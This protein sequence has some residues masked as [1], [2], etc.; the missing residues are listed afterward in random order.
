[1]TASANGGGNGEPVDRS[2]SG[3]GGDAADRAEIAAL[4]ARVAELEAAKA[5]AA[6]APAPVKKHRIR[7]FFS[8]LLIFLAW[9]LAPLAVVAAWS[10]SVVGDT[11]RYVS[12]VAPLAR[13]P[14][15]QQS[16]ANR[17]TDAIMSHLDIQ[18]LVQ[19]A[20]PADRPRLDAVLQKA[21]GPV[22]S[23]LTSFVHEQTLNL[24]QS[25]WFASFWDDAN[26]AAHASVDKLLTGQGGGAVQVKNGAVTIDL[27]PVVDKVKTQLVAK[28]VTVADKIP[29]VHTDITVMQAEHI[30]KYRTY[31][32][33]LQILGVWLPFVF[34]AC[35]AGGVL[36]AK[37]RRHALIVAG[38]G[39]FVAAALVGIGVRAGRTFYLNALPADVSQ[40][41]AS[42]VYDIMSRFLITTNR[43]VAILGLL[44]ALA[45]FLAGPTRVAGAVRGFWHA[46]IDSTRQFADHLGMRTGPVG[47]FVYRFRS[48]ITWGAVVI[49]GVV[50]LLW[51][52]PTG[53]VVFWL[54]LACLLVLLVVDFLSE[55]PAAGSES[56]K[57]AG[58]QT[59]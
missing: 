21:A 16:V 13:N 49:A 24:V 53:M 33:L 40:A 47:A 27:A 55:P 52:Y 48:W 42:A 29:Q 23:A 25:D 18:T 30:N 17:T 31:F 44:V 54:A 58:G 10:A 2:A 3:S 1:M 57:T 6:A 35:V 14:D 56:G 36:L 37:N 28:G 4:R 15:I 5:S 45:A 12:T 34:L 46:G 20:A 51:H 19:E 22:T 26:R 50:L 59:A 41:S 32:R 38:L 8:A 9:I 7:S 43:T 39:V 11:G